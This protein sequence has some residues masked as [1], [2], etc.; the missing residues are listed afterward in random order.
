M[1]LR[2][3]AFLALAAM[4]ASAAILPTTATAATDFGYTY[5]EARYLDI[6]RD[7][8]SDADGLTAIGWYRLN[9]RFFL[10]GQFIGVNNDGGGDAQTYA[11]GAG[12]I[13]PLSNH[14]V[15]VLIPSFRHVELDS[16]ARTTSDDGYAVQLGLRG[17]PVPKFEARAFVN[18]VD[19]NR[20][21][22]SF[23]LS[24]DYWF[25]SSLSAGLAAELGENAN[26]I[27]LGVRYAFG[28]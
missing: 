14:W 17:M 9:K 12:F 7:K 24:G 8:G 16:G 21:E 3:R 2:T 18:Y 4:A 22:T 6:D 26:T 15:A 5:A 23:L 13:Q 27:S 28:F 25:S 11:A 1:Q 20:G 10:L 19:V